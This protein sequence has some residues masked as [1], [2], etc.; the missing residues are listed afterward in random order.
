[1]KKTFRL[2]DRPILFI[3]AWTVPLIF[4]TGVLL[5]LFG[6]PAPISSQWELLLVYVPL[7]LWGLYLV[8]RYRSGFPRIL[9]YLVFFFPFLL[10]I[11]TILG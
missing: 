9:S 11:M 7:F 5:G 3:I 1:M 4:L 8:I 2:Q 6:A 10:V